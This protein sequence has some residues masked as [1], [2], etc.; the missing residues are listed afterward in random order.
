MKRVGGGGGGILLSTPY[1]DSL[2]SDSF[3]T[4]GNRWHLDCFRCNTCSTL[5]DSDANLLLLGDGSLIC[6]NCT[7]SCTVCNNKIEDLAILTGDQAFCSTCFRCRNCKRKIENLR[8]A[9]TSQGIFC[10]Q[11]HETLMA[12]RRKKSK[13]AAAAKAREKEHSP[14]VMEKS[15]PAL[16]P[17]VIPNG[18]F[19]NERV[20]PDSD[21]PT[22]LSPRPRHSQPLSDALSNSRSNSRSARSPERSDSTSKPDGLGLSSPAYPKNRNSATAAND[23]TSTESPDS[24]FIPV[25]FDPSPA[26]ATSSHRQGAEIRDDLSRRRDQLSSHRASGASDKRTDSHASTPHIAFQEKGRAHSSDYEVRLPSSKLSK[27]T[28]PEVSKSASS[29]VME[30][31]PQKPLETTASRDRYSDS[32]ASL[33]L[34]TPEE[35]PTSVNGEHGLE[36]TT[37]NETTSPVRSSHDSRRREDGENEALLDVASGPARPPPVTQRSIAR[38][39]LPPTAVV[40]GTY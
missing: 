11:C 19:S 25:A 17:N 32:Q 34:A 31:K 38:K 6:N 40:A 14:M 12:R 26:P 2:S 37:T 22:E 4:A 3:F 24:F 39:E 7:Y 15:L 1:C 10:M 30:A 5:L 16:P 29:S 33:A 35:S 23:R 28:Q 13:A 18:A 20:D 8:Y 27:P 9:R 21:N 36:P